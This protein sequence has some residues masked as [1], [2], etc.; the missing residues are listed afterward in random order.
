MMGSAPY[1]M[2]SP[3]PALLPFLHL[4][5]HS[6]MLVSAILE[7][8]L[9]WAG[10]LVSDFPASRTVYNKCHLSPWSVIGCY[11]GQAG[12]DTATGKLDSLGESV[13]PFP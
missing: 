7:A 6:R 10:T 2:P 13:L 1:R 9:N 11:S 5:G 12:C 4:G 8:G 3:S